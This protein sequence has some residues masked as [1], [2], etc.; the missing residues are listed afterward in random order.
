LVQSTNGHHLVM[1]IY[2]AFNG[3]M[4]DCD[5]IDERD[6]INE[7]IN[8]FIDQVSVVQLVR[9]F[10]RRHTL[11]VDGSKLKLANS[12]VRCLDVAHLEQLGHAATESNRLSIVGRRSR[13]QG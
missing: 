11:L 9:A 1:N 5:L 7:F 2:D 8:E 10:D 4:V 12:C 3:E 13:R 6:S